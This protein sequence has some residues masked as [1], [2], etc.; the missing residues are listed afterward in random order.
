LSCTYLA[1]HELESV[2]IIIIII[3]VYKANLYMAA[4][5]SCITM[6]PSCCVCRTELAELNTQSICFMLAFGGHRDTVSMFMW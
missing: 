1:H 6:A 5:S 4:A 3:G 2:L